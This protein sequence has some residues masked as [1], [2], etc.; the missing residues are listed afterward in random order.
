MRLEQC[1]ACGAVLRA[2]QPCPRCGAV[3]AIAAPRPDP[4]GLSA[5]D[6]TMRDLAKP[7]QPAKILP[8]KRP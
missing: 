6:K 8:F 4:L 1:G 5:L 7:D 3:T 2:R